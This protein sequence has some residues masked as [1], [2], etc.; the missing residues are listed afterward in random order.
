MEVATT[1][2]KAGSVGVLLRTLDEI[3][4]GDVARPDWLELARE[5]RIDRLS[6]TLRSQVLGRLHACVRRGFVSPLSR[7]LSPRRHLALWQEIA[8]H[9]F[10]DFGSHGFAKCYDSPFVEDYDYLRRY[11]SGGLAALD[12]YEVYSSVLGT[13]DFSVEDFVHTGLCQEVRT[14]VEPMAGSAE[15]SYHGHFRYPDFRYVMFD[16]DRSARHHVL[17]RNW[18]PET[19][20]H[21]LVADVL[22]EEVWQQTKSLTTGR[23]LCYLGKQSHHFFGAR[24]LLRLMDLATRHVDFFVLEVPPPTLMTDLPETDDLTRPEMEAAGLRVAL[25]DDPERRPNLITNRMAFRLEASDETGV[26]TLFEYQGWTFWQMPML[27]TLADLLGLRML[28][29]HS[30]EHEFCPVDRGLESA[31]LD[32]NIAFLAFTRHLG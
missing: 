7:R 26:R 17:Q 15:F 3:E 10:H 8:R 12:P 18:L 13:H 28:Y 2:E 14:V 6:P 25:V 19:E 9:G 21:Y 27:A 20:H 22:D 29:F 4:R 31:D 16:L 23:S 32:E 11:Q 5:A 1:H 30:E 24:D